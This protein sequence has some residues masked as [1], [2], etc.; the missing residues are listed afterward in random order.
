LAIFVQSG[1]KITICKLS[2]LTES[3]I[4]LELELPIGMGWQH[5]GESDANDGRVDVKNRGQIPYRVGFLIV[6]E[7]DLANGTSRDG[8]GL[9]DL[10]HKTARH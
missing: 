10:D 9:K 4:F 5:L 3:T 8:K 1:L 7:R 6:R 2:K